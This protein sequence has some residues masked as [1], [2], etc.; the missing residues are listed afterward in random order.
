MSDHVQIHSEHK[1]FDFKL[2]YFIRR[3]ETLPNFRS[4]C[5]INLQTFLFPCERQK[6]RPGRENNKVSFLNVISQV[7]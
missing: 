4:F 2:I 3:T 1:K 6:T 5:V 7:E